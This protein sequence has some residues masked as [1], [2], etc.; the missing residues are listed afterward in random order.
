MRLHARSFATA[1]S[2]ALATPLVAQDTSA[3]TPAAIME[4]DSASWDAGRLEGREAANEA[5]VAHRA[6]MGFIVG[7][8]MGFLAL[9]AAYTA[10]PIL[11]GGEAI[12]VAAVVGLGR[13]GNA[14]PAESLVQRA[15]SR[16]QEYASG[17]EQGYADRLRS[18]RM[19]A[20]AGGAIAGVA[21]GAGL[22][23]WAILHSD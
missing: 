5:I 15:A 20:A 13:V 3:S 11:I 16:G 9:P 6:L 14:R 17:M 12:A 19:K 23:L 4:A 10:S 18:R 22:L 8:P 1:C 21:T 2:I 7:V